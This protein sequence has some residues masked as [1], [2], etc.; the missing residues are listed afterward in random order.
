MRFKKHGIGRYSTTDDDGT[1]FVIGIPRGGGGFEIR[2]DDA[3]LVSPRDAWHTGT[4]VDELAMRDGYISANGAPLRFA[5]LKD[6]KDWI[7]E[8]VDGA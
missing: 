5:A 3:D 8:W 7:R 2:V 1:L 6:A 4:T